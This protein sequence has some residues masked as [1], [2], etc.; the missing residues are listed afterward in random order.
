VDAIRIEEQPD[1]GIVG[2]TVDAEACTVCGA[3]LRVCPGRGVDFGELNQRVFGEPPSDVVMGHIDEAFVTWSTDDEIRYHSASGGIATTLL[4][5]LLERGE[6]DGA[7][8][9]TA[10]PEHAL[11]PQAVLATTVEEIK[12][13]SGSKYCPVSLDAGLAEVAARPGR[14][15]VVGLPCHLQG[16]RALEARD[17][18]LAE[19]IVLHLGLMCGRNSTFWGTEYFLRGKGVDP[20]AVTA[21]DYRAKGWPG[22]ICVTLADGTEECFARSTSDKSF[23]GQRL[24]HSAFHFDFIVPRCLTC[25]DTFAILADVSLGDAWL[26]EIKA[27]ERVGKSII[28]VRTAAG[29]RAID[30]L[31]E[32]GKIERESLDPAR[33]KSRNLTFARNYG[34]RMQILRGLGRAVPQYEIPEGARVFTSKSSLRPVTATLT[35][36]PFL[37]SLISRSRRNWWLVTVLGYARQVM[38]FGMAMALGFGSGFHRLRNPERWK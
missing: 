13:T 10:N 8:V 36:G 32:R 27:E 26:P 11:R 4:C 18:T 1:R 17:K 31:A 7:V 38:I 30:L 29:R 5:D 22:K 9:V 3:C 20:A 24:F 15:A 34:Y 2:P 6:I 21:I 16:I 19:R 28:I 12:A 37:P 23:A 35:F 33:L 25:F 14:Y